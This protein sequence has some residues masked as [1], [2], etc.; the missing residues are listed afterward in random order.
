MVGQGMGGRT[1]EEQS[2]G[3]VRATVQHQCTRIATVAEHRIAYRIDHNL[4]DKCKAARLEGY[5]YVSGNARNSPNSIPCCPTEL[6]HDHVDFST[7][8]SLWHADA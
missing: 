5:R 8:S 2:D 6:M 3:S 1:P 4:I 7:F